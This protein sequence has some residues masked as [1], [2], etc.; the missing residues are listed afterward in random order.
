MITLGVHNRM[1]RETVSLAAICALLLAACGG[2]SPARPTPPG[3][4]SAPTFFSL[5]GT[6]NADA[7]TRPIA[8]ARIEISDGLDAGRSA[9]TGADGRYLLA[10]LRPG[11][12]SIRVTADGYESQTRSVTLVADA[13]AD[14]GLRATDGPPGRMLVGSVIDG[15]TDGS[16]AGATLDIEGVGA[17]TT[18]ADGS[19]R[20]ET[21]DVEQLRPVSIRSGSTVQRQ[22]HLRVPGP[23]ARLSLIPS[24]FDLGAFDQMFRAAG[25][26]FRWTEAP[27]LTIQTRVLQFT[28]VTDT[29]YTATDATLTDEEVNQLMADL[30][31]GLPQLTGDRFRSFADQRRETATAGSLVPVRRTG[32]IVVAR[33]AGLTA[34][35]NFWGYGRWGSS[36]PG[37]VVAGIV[38]LDRDFEQSGSPFRRSLRVHELG[39]SLGYN[40]VTSRTS[41]MNS[42]ARVEP[43]DFDRSA[44]K[45]A[46][47]RP[48]ANRSPDA[49]PDEF[50]SNII[51]S[52]G[53]LIWSGAH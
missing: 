48:P 38:M 47:L 32:E 14:F 22:T 15:I 20:I 11:G 46:F 7:P 39:H 53:V 35:T 6:V 40:H 27:R 13:V 42:S 17:V 36:A 52:S 4:P 29:S 10:G 5:S 28:N 44:A 8:G 31:W 26:L 9:T 41:V 24:T 1:R 51:R 45:L 25:S 19:F 50:S 49:D 21:S 23:D 30:T 33:Y 3:P 34:A 2:G 37:T 12:F 43:N 18:G 16:I